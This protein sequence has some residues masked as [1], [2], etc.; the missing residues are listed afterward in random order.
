ML[1][2]MKM[3]WPACPATLQK[4]SGAPLPPE[5]RNLSIAKSANLLVIACAFVAVTGLATEPPKL[6]PVEKKTYKP[7]DSQQL[8]YQLL[9]PD[10]PD[11]A[12]ATQPLV[13]W[14]H[15]AG[16]FMN[17]QIE[18]DWWPA[19]KKAGCFL[20]LPESKSKN[21]W[22]P[23]EAPFVMNCI[24]DAIARHA[25]I[26]PRRVVLFG[27]SA[28][29]QIALYLGG[30]QGDKLAGIVTMAA[31][32]INPQKGQLMLPPPAYK[33]KTSY[34]LICGRN[35][36]GL[37]VCRPAVFQMRKQGFNAL[38][39]EV[40]GLAHAFA[41]SE[42]PAIVA[43]IASLEQGKKPVDPY[44]NQPN[45]CL[46]QIRT[47]QKDLLTSKAKAPPDGK[48]VKLGTTSFSIKAPQD[49][50]NNPQENQLMSLSRLDGQKLLAGLNAQLCDKPDVDEVLAAM[51]ERTNLSGQASL[52]PVSRAH[53]KIGNRAWTACFNLVKEGPDVDML[54]VHAYC[55]TKA[56]KSESLIFSFFMP[57][58]KIE[59]IKT[60][61]L[62]YGLLASLT[63]PSAT[64]NL[65]ALSPGGHIINTNVPCVSQH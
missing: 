46:E 18:Q 17:K 37:R 33:D 29:G 20:I 63:G 5:W 34:F 44:A 65:P 14:L 53:L 13:V 3:L 59:K 40:P 24:D 11:T 55:H 58:E 43:W 32:P 35:D 25:Q 2:A 12:K 62:L 1:P 36:G 27:Y 8:S 6:E 54:V 47:F 60:A 31:Y 22:A 64:S 15:P 45:P 19:L 61:D 39:T 38:L 57:I 10:V 26:S 41:P 56:D 48:T 4:R 21:T 51:I 42:K 9:T 16:D 7:K 23:D 52:E 49:W 50:Q 28:G 30:T